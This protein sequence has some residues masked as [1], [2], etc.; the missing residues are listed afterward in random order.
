M[1]TKTEYQFITEELANRLSD[2]MS[3]YKREV[4]CEKTDPASETQ[5]ARDIASR[6]TKLLD[7]H[8]AP[9][10]GR[11][12]CIVKELLNIIGHDEDFLKRYGQFK[13]TQF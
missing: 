8:L 2:M 13:Y 10:P 6:I 7:L 1:A 4:E 3:L 5:L 11:R 12:L 9:E